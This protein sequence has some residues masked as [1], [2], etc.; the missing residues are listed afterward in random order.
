MQDARKLICVKL[1]IKTE[2]NLFCKGSR[3][4]REL[5]VQRS[6]KDLQSRQDSGNFTA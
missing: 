3:P 5:L 6:V 1:R 2:T 4:R